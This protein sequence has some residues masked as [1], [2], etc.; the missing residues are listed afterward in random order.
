MITQEVFLLSRVFITFIS[1][2]IFKNVLNIMILMYVF[3]V[4][5]FILGV[6]WY[7]KPK[8]TDTVFVRNE[9]YDYTL[10]ELVCDIAGYSIVVD[11]MHHG[12]LNKIHNYQMYISMYLF[13]VADLIVYTTTGFTN[14][15]IFKESLLLEVVHNQK[16]TIEELIVLYITKYVMTYIGTK[17][18][19]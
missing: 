7:A 13:K 17:R 14:I 11:R 9:M 16:A 6:M 8:A 5:N 15:D 18:K 12:H 3:D 4:I 19:N 2:Y 1:P 10:L